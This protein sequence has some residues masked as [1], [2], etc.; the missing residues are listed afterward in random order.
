MTVMEEGACESRGSPYYNLY[1]L[2]AF[3]ER[4]GQHFS[5]RNGIRLVLFYRY[6]G[7]MAMVGLSILF[8]VGAALAAVFGFMVFAGIVGLLFRVLLVVLFILFVITYLK[9]RGRAIPR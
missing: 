8:L 3:R 2:T 6:R 7:E 1:E 5:F 4:K 9:G